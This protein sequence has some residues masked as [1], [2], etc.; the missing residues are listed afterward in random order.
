VS[1]LLAEALAV[2]PGLRDATL[3]ETRV[4]FRPPAHDGLPLVGRIADG[5]FVATG[6]GPQGL[7]AGPWTGLAVAALV[8]GEP[9]VTDLTPFAPDRPVTQLR[10]MA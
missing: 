4:G 2:A 5:L 1:G 8:L 6:H 10:S 3:L 9:P 7:T